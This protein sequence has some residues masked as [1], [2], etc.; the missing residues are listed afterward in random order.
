[1]LAQEVKPSGI[2]WFFVNK[3][4]RPSSVFEVAVGFVIGREHHGLLETTSPG[5]SEGV[6]RIVIIVRDRSKNT[7]I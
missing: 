1:M 2:R 6:N 5:E 3:K 4:N 7:V